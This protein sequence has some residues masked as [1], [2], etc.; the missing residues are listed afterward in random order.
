MVVGNKRHSR[1]GKVAECNRHG[2]KLHGGKAQ[3]SKRKRVNVT[4]LQAA[5][6]QSA[7]QQADSEH[8]P[9]RQQELAARGQVVKGKAGTSKQEVRQQAA[10][11]NDSG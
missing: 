11:P 1:H 7:W 8:Q 4:S 9:I 2:H 5:K 3:C 6:H 10:R